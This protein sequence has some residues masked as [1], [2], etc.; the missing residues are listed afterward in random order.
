MSAPNDDQQPA[1]LELTDDQQGPAGDAPPV[2]ED[3]ERDQ[4]DQEDGGGGQEAAKY[5]RRLRAAEKER[6]ALQGRL[7]GLQRAEVERLAGSQLAKPAG[8]WASGVEL[9]DLLA[10][11]GS[12][13]PGRVTAAAAAAVDTLGLRRRLHNYVPNE[14]RIPQATKSAQAEMLRVISG[15]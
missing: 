13:D 14:G 8:L 4:D 9:G 15:E 7:E 5:R 2:E 1:E 10:V 3:E 11:D 12:V 6:D